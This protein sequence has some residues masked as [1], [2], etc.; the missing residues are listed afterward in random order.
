MLGAIWPP[1]SSPSVIKTH[2]DFYAKRPPKTFAQVMARIGALAVTAFALGGLVMILSSSP[3]GGNQGPW[4]W[5]D[6]DI[7]K[8]FMPI[9]S[10]EENDRRF[11]EEVKKMK[12]SFEFVD[13]Q[14]NT[15]KTNDR[16]RLPGEVPDQPAPP[17]EPP[18]GD[19]T[20]ERDAREAE[21]TAELT[22]GPWLNLDDAVSN[23]T[24]FE[25]FKDWR[26]QYRSHVM[27]ERDAN[28][29]RQAPPYELLAFKILRQI[30][31]VGAA[32]R[33]EYESKLE[34]GK[35]Y[36]GAGQAAINAC[37]GRVFEAKGRLF[38]LYEVKL[39][40]PVVLPDGSKVE[41]Y[42]EG[43]ISFLRQG[44]AM[45][46]F[47][48]TQQ[49]VLF[50]S[51]N[52]PDSLVKYLGKQDG[53]YH[54]DALATENVFVSCS[55]VYLRNFV[56]SRPV[57]PFSTNEKRV[58][59][60]AFLPL[61]LTND[62]SQTEH[63]GYALT[64]GLLQQVRDSVREDVEYLQDEAAYYAM[65]A[66]ANT[67][68]DSF[69]V[70]P[71]VGYFDLANLDT[72]PKY[73]GQG[74]RV[75]GLIGDNYSPVILPPNISGIRRVYRCYVAGSM[76]DLAT[77]N[78]YLVDMIELPPG[79]EARAPVMFDARYYRNVFE[80]QG[81]GSMIRPLLVVHHVERHFQAD[82][83]QDWIFA[84]VL[85]GGAAIMF[86][87]FVWFMFS[88]RRSRDKFEQQNMAR[89]RERLEKSGGLK[90]KPL[91]KDSS[92]PSIAPGTDAT[93]AKPPEP[94]K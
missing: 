35:F 50:Q 6:R 13:P 3:R 40:S 46:E 75:W 7:R 78:R 1:T 29:G 73:R 15:P 17:A 33:K 34:P 22:L 93:G 21:L 62:L 2:F 60:Q 25:P 89:L 24:T 79:L 20:T 77:P 85:I 38:D 58:E 9:Y 90:L 92:A 72:G 36:F 84:L 63:E 4:P 10:V 55:G 18:P 51:L 23:I 52:C 65:L 88:D 12:G 47:P 14:T 61:L 54:D 39:T 74:L 80:A 43:S 64:D 86:V 91:P 76:S 66:Q 37:R 81:S 71:E 68:G 26:P 70:V 27:S 44:R 69:K 42:F 57:K 59:S 28:R 8:N 83:S 56:Y 49:Q 31:A 45:G 48:I 53:L 41:R 67:K 94:Q 11:N 87:G 16:P 30:P 5:E 32:G 19:P 82:R